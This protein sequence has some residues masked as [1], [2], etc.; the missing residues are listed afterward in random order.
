[1][2]KEM[3]GTNM[4]DTAETQVSLEDIIALNA[5]LK[6]KAD[7]FEGDVNRA[8]RI[9]YQRLRNEEIVRKLLEFN[10]FAKYEDDSRKSGI[11]ILKNL[12]RIY[13]TATPNIRDVMLELLGGEH[14]KAIAEILLDD[15]ARPD[16]T[17]ERTL[18]YLSKDI[19]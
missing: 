14:Y 10:I 8:I 13:I 3:I 18:S 12:S 2:K 19:T 1:M 17:Y 11:A 9:M 16:G 5:V 15:I 6:V 4:S 7:R